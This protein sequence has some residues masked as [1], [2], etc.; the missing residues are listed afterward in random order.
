MFKNMKIRNSLLFG[1]VIS[2]GVSLIIIIAA[3][4]NM[5]SMRSTFSDI[6]AGEV[7]ANKLMLQVRL[8]SNIA[9][10]NLREFVITG[11]SANKDALKTKINDMLDDVNK[12]LVDLQNIGLP[13]DEINDYIKEVN[14]WQKIVPEIIATSESGDTLGAVNMIQNTCTPVLETMFTTAEKIYED[15]TKAKEARME[16]L[17]TKVVVVTVILC[18]VLIISLIAIFII[19]RRII[20]SIVSPTEQVR[21]A[22][23][24]FSH[25]NFDVPV[26]FESKNELG[27]MCEA[28]RTS[29]NVLGEVIGDE[30]ELLEQ[31]AGGNFTVKSKDR[32]LYVG[33]LES[34]V[35][36]IASIKLKLNDAL[37]KIHESADQ[38]SASSEHVSSGAQALSQGATEQ[39]ASV[40]ELAATIAEI[41]D[42]VRRNAEN[43]KI[44]SQKANSVGQ[45]VMHSN[46]LMHEMTMAMENIK[47]KSQEISKIIK[48]I[49][50][51]AFQTDILALNAA[52]EAARAGAAGKGFA[53][54]ADEVRN[55]ANKS[56]EASKN[57]AVLIEDSVEAVENGSR[58]ATETAQTLLDVVEGT[59]EIVS[60]IDQISE[61]SQQ[62]ADSILQV[63]QGVDQISSVV[64]TNSA[65]A[66][67]SAA[68]SQELSSQANILKM[69][70]SQFT[71]E[72]IENTTSDY[73]PDYNMEY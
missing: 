29:Q 4:L 16:A 23:V 58:I 36:S 53:V 61:A 57:T 56:A 70:V 1:F 35:G 71:L 38:V 68:T 26:E 7:E 34:V 46:E 40:E 22:L 33:A 41:S 24:A 43:T 13:E 30:C 73:M 52:V 20:H 72:G 39:A 2:V 59:K 17:N 45:D 63:T 32:S 42:Q 65:T 25:G 14:D 54:V 18:I 62:Q 21:N 37:G 66:Q 12:K 50:D 44:G 31:M 28:L 69:L 11:D 19:V 3:V 27:D 49:E 60:A 67:Q 48:T 9:A 5:N 15:L 8:E 47:M 51:I 55:L 64:Q 10:R 6:N